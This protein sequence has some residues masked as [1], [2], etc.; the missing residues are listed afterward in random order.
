[1]LTEAAAWAATH[2]YWSQVA[3]KHVSHFVR[4]CLA[5]RGLLEQLEDARKKG[6]AQ[7]AAVRPPSWDPPQE[8]Q[9]GDSKPLCFHGDD[10]SR[11]PD[12]DCWCHKE[13]QAEASFEVE[14][15]EGDDEFRTAFEIVED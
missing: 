10:C 9:R 6:K 2:G 11:L 1:L 13:E 3:G 12:C 5:E 15:D 8:R 4:T 7:A 14:P